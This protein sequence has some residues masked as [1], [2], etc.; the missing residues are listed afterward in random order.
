MA[1]VIKSV[2]WAAVAVLVGIALRRYWLSPTRRVPVVAVV[3]ATAALPVFGALDLWNTVSQVRSPVPFEL[4]WRYASTT[5]H[6]HA[7]A[8]RSVATVLLALCVTLAPRSWWP[9]AAAAGVWLCYGFSRLSH[10]A[11]MGGAVPLAYDLVHLAGAVVW[12]GA[13]WVVAFTRDD[14]RSTLRLSRLALWSVVVLGIAGSFSALVHAGEPPRFFGSAYALVLGVKLLAVGLALVLAARNR[15]V[16]V[17]RAAAK[18]D[19]D[20]LQ[21]SLYLESGVLLG[22]LVLT[23]WLSTTAVP[24]GQETSLGAIENLRRVMEHLLR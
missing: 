22:V 16:L 19:R 2:S 5:A 9:V 3:A 1:I 10:A 17:P 14:L 6:G 21:R 20:G 23:G 11:A 13:V 15:F 4:W 8:W 18:G 7:V 24:H 12:A